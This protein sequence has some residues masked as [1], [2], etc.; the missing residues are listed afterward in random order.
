MSVPV[1]EKK[2]K[3]ADHVVVPVPT[4]ESRNCVRCYRLEKV[5]RKSRMKCRFCNKHFCFN[6]NRNC[7][8]DDHPL[9]DI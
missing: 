3:D 2:K 1:Y 8:L 9:S 5:E 7:L 6:N 4:T